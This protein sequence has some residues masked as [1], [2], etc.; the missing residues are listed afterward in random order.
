MSIIP[1]L[2]ETKNKRILK[3]FISNSPKKEE[4]LI[5]GVI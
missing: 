5:L 3:K 2:K 1:Q 4:N